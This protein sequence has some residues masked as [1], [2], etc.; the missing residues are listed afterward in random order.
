MLYLLYA[1]ESAFLWNYEKKVGHTYL[2]LIK[3]N[4]IS[5]KNIGTQIF[6]EKFIHN[7]I[8]TFYGHFK[9]K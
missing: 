5:N 1:I 7:F 6:I 9:V 2:N 4:Y 3:R 8:K